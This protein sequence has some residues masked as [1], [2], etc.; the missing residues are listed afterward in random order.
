[1]YT[2]SRSHLLGG[3]GSYL[4]KHVWSVRGGGGLPRPNGGWRR[5]RRDLN[6]SLRNGKCLTMFCTKL[7]REFEC[8]NRRGLPLTSNVHH[9][10]A[11]LDERPLLSSPPSSPILHRRRERRKLHL[12]TLYFHFFC[13]MLYAWGKKSECMLYA[14]YIFDI[15]KGSVSMI[16]LQKWRGFFCKNWRSVLHRIKVQSAAKILPKKRVLP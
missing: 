10:W 8:L 9:N 2:E 16:I 4:V 1:M 13:P 5:P 15:R 3:G 11:G 12:T 6:C 7:G 14:Q